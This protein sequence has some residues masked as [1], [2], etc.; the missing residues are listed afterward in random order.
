MKNYEK[1][2]RYNYE[3]DNFI[4]GKGSS[5]FSNGGLNKYIDNHHGVETILKDGIKVFFRPYPKTEGSPVVEV[6]LIIGDLIQ[7]IHFLQR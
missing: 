6:K 5:L 3:E 4:E 1:N 7:K 2:T